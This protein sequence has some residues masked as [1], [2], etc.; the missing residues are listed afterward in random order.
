MWMV[1][2]NKALDR[3][4]HKKGTRI[5]RHRFSNFDHNIDRNLLAKPRL[6]FSK[7]LYFFTGGYYPTPI[8]SFEVIFVPSPH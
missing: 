4:R 8:N 6:N 2:N 3:S 5:I 7:V 1:K